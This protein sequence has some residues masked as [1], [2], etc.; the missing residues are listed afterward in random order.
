MTS[1]ILE[2]KDMLMHLWHLTRTAAL[3]IDGKYGH[4]MLYRKGLAPWRRLLALLL[5]GVSRAIAEIAVYAGLRAYST[6]V[7]RRNRNRTDELPSLEFASVDR[8][9]F[10][11]Q[12]QASG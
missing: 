12:A 5:P 9:D 4:R 6:K 1:I 11:H 2:G 8:L 3:D 7:G 10:R